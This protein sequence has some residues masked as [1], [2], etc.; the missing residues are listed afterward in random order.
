MWGTVWEKLLGQLR[1]K[2]KVILSESLLVMALDGML[3]LEMAMEWV[4]T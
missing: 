2:Q 3:G 4:K 1:A